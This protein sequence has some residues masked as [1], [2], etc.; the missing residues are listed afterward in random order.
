MALASRKAVPVVYA[1]KSVSPENSTT[2]PS[3]S[4]SSTRAAVPFRTSAPLAKPDTK[5]SGSINGYMPAFAPVVEGPISCSP[6][7]CQYPKSGAPSVTGLSWL[8]PTRNIVPG[9]PRPAGV[10]RLEVVNPLATANGVPP[11]PPGRA[12]PTYTPPSAIQSAM[13]FLARV[14]SLVDTP[15]TTSTSYSSFVS[16]PELMDEPESR[17]KGT[18]HCLSSVNLRCEEDSP[19]PYT[20]IFGWVNATP[21]GGAPD[22]AV[23]FRRNAAAAS[24]TADAEVAGR[25]K[26]P[27]GRPPAASVR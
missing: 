23:T 27:A 24:L 10:D 18:P 17:L 16:A 6:S 11:V 2:R 13:S 22:A 19:P 7:P 12:V 20:A 14:R 8:S 3:P 26:A 1:R 4:F 9:T 15:G 5:K 21:D 25:T